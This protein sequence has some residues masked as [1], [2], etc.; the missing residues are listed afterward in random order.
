MRKHRIHLQIVWH[1]TI[2]SR[3][4]R[5]DVCGTRLSFVSRLQPQLDKEPLA[6]KHLEQKLSV[7]TTDLTT[8][9]RIQRL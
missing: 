4:H 1:S 3:H 7:N 6:C 9:I 5:F 2:A 8:R